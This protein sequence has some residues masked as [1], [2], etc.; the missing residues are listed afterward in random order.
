MS[1]GN[2]KLKQQ[3]DAPTQ[4]LEQL[5]SKALTVL[6]ADEAVEQQEL[7]FST[8]GNA[9]WRHHFGRQFGSFLQNRTHSYRTVQQSRSVVLTQMN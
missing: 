7:E 2:Y 9:R 8:D 4:I 3:W 5:K 6:N 1:L